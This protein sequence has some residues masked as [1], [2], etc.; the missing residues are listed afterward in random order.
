MEE[1]WRRCGSISG[2]FWGHRGGPVVFL[3][4]CTVYDDLPGIPIVGHS[5]RDVCM[6]VNYLCGNDDSYEYVRW[7]V[8]TSIRLNYHDPRRDM[9]IS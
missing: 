6:H 5:D 9:S 8:D 7:C 2:R 3:P 4:F 1:M